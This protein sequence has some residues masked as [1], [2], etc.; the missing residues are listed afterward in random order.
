MGDICG[1]SLE[2][3]LVKKLSGLLVVLHL[4]VGTKFLKC[5]SDAEFG[6]SI[7]LNGLYYALYDP[8]M[9]FCGSVNNGNGAW[10]VSYIV[11]ILEK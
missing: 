8:S 1:S 9:G 6:T 11:H 4:G 7:A 10:E 2:T 3:V 5:V